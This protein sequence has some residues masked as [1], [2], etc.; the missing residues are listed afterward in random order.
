MKPDKGKTTMRLKNTI[1]AIFLAL[2]VTS[3]PLH[4]E[5]GVASL[6]LMPVPKSVMLG[7]GK[8]R[9]TPSFAVAAKKDVGKRLYAAASRTLRRLSDRTGLFFPQDFVTSRSN[10][11]SASMLIDCRRKGNV[12]L[13]EDESYSLTITPGKVELSSETDLGALRGF[14][15]LLQLLSIDD[16]GY[17]LPAVT[18]NDEPRFLWRGL[19]ID[20]S[21]HFM[22]V[23]VIKR[24]LDGMA[25]LKMNVFHWHL[26]DDQGVRVESKKFPKLQELCSDG[27]YY[28]Q[29]QIKEVLA[30]AEDRG[31]R[32]IPEFDLPGHS[33]AWFAAFPGLASAPGPYTIERHWGIFDPTFNPTIEA[34]YRFLDR[35]LGEMAFLF[36]DEYLH[37]GGDE[38]NGKQWSAN[39]QIQ[40][41]MKKHKI[42]DNH[43]LQAYFNNRLL[44]ILTKHGKK[45]IGWDE[46]L[47]P[48]MPT[49][50]VIQ[51][52]RGPKGLFEAARRGYKAILSN[53]YY[54]DLIQSAEFHYL[55]DPL[56]ADSILTEEAK[57][58]ILGGEAT[59]W[60]ELVTPETIDSR[61]WPRTAAIAERFWS[62]GNVRDV[63]DMYR[64]LD[65]ISFRLEE[66]GLTHAKNYD[67]MLRRLTNN[68]DIIA[69]KTFIDVIEPV[70]I[71]KRH[72]QGVT[73]TQF[74]PLTRA[75][76]A[77]RPESKTARLFGKLVDR[78][79]K[80]K[81][82]AS[83]GE[84]K[85]HLTV[86]KENDAK[87]RDIIHRSP[88]LW[89]M[90]TMSKDLADISAIALEAAAMIETG[91][92]AEQ[93]WVD[94]K[95]AILEKAKLPGGQAEL[96][97]VSAI[98]QLVSAAG[99]K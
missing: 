30:Y 59:S 80:K 79:V 95:L 77:A 71:Y 32:V 24:N 45:M 55:N 9:L 49:T 33:T 8:F 92:K 75:V 89:E 5:E 65:V 53:G 62:P 91:K 7:S 72:S 87:L 20:V 60:A 37:I 85:A 48:Q 58:N 94:D 16:E 31:I 88:I 50:I 28:T 35:F 27:F 42:A 78:F 54:I 11:D 97:V 66:L 81:D 14:E 26:S 39:K 2:L 83:L 17:Y 86:W 96:M 36:P 23:E 99:G 98:Q 84:I 63:D 44:K 15:T 3:A 69:L 68:A 21:R 40:A 67:M 76:D 18:I 74:S 41:F 12:V 46:I 19:M 38:N 61:I 10:P 47:Q 29:A 57:K 52:W 4:S 56:P 22:S 73:Y 64:R 90:A 1:I 82:A 43:A 25:A 6:N 13:G 70:K 51:S 93:A 34:T